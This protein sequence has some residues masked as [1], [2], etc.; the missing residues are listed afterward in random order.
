MPM[1]TKTTCPLPFFDEGGPLPDPERFNARH[2]SDDHRHNDVGNSTKKDVVKIILRSS[3]AFSVALLVVPISACGQSCPTSSSEF[4]AQASLAILQPASGSAVVHLE[5]AQPTVVSI[6]LTAGPLVSETTH[7]VVSG[8]SV[9]FTAGN[10]SGSL[11]KNLSSGTCVDILATISNDAAIGVSIAN[12]FNLGRRIGQLKAIRYD[13]PLNFTVEGDG[14]VTSSVRVQYGQDISIALKN[15]DDLTY[16][17]TPSLYCDGEETTLSPVTVGPGSTTLVRFS[18]SNNWF[19]WGT[20]FRTKAVALRV[21]VRLTPSAFGDTVHDRLFPSRSV[22][23]NAHLARLSPTRSQFFTSGILFVVLLLGGLA[24]LAIN[25]IL[26]NVLRKLSY[27]KKLRSLADSTSAVSIKVDSRL[28]VVLR[29]ERNRLLQLLASL[30]LFSTDAVDVFQQV[31]TGIIALGKRVTTA[32][33]LDELRNQFDLR[34]TSSPPSISDNIDECLQEA[35][36][37]L[38]SLYLSDKIIDGAN[39]ALDSAEQKLNALSAQD[40]LAKDIASRHSQLLARVNCFQNDSLASLKEA[41]PG[42]VEVLDEKFDDEHPVL[43][44]NFM[45]VDDSIARMNVALD[46]VYIYSTTKD[47]GI[48]ARLKERSDQLIQLLGTRDWRTLRSAR[49]LVQ[50]M[51]QNIYPEDLIDALRSKRANISMDQQVARPYSALELCI[52]FDCYRYNHAKALEHLS[53]VWNFDDGLTEKGWSICHFYQAPAEKTISAKIPLS[54]PNVP[55]TAQGP[56]DNVVFSS[57]LTVRRAK[58]TFSNQS[59]I[60]ETLR[61]AVAFFLALVSLIA[62]AQDQLVKLDVVPALIAV[63]LL[64]FGA[65]AIKNVLTQQSTQPS[66]PVGK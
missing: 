19:D 65:D 58:S 42:I 55:A 38:R 46:S 39:L 57:T 13:A 29:L 28:R 36:D 50:Q 25:S 15:N 41:L 62:G 21:V 7:A 59:R 20:W 35:A 6:D 5:N 9:A 64:G 31:D 4:T 27:K 63:F 45:Q 10:G 14:S 37:Q 61:F 56:S 32:Q 60:A 23:V 26:P 52:C 43:P 2:H 3:F 16:P 18:T 22:P 11:P 54:V 49:D 33:R 40:V 44:T 12:I 53:C 51:R 66:T 48:Q 1:D 24:S 34:S 30:S 17:I 8:A 47:V